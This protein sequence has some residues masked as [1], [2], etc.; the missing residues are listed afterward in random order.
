MYDRFVSQ[1]QTA[2]ACGPVSFSTMRVRKLSVE[3][4]VVPSTV[5]APDARRRPWT[6]ARVSLSAHRGNCA[7]ISRAS[8]VWMLRLR[9]TEHAC[10]RDC[11][12]EAIR[13]RNVAP[14]VHLYVIRA[15]LDL[16]GISSLD[17]SF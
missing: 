4:T 13:V 8:A 12:K 14:Q 9:R 2:A 15:A 6:P 7:S 3:S 17:G 5:K 16:L 11:R 10:Y 1:S